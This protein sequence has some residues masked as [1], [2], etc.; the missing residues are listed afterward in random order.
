[1]DILGLRE[2]ILSYLNYKELCDIRLINKHYNNIIESVNTN[3]IENNIRDPEIWKRKFSKSIGIKITNKWKDDDLMFL[4]NI[5]CLA[6]SSN[7]YLTDVIL[8]FRRLHTLSISGSWGLLL[9]NRPS[10]YY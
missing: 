1:M 8:T 7:A 6:L 4:K 5:Q 3:D 9:H 2:Y 10:F